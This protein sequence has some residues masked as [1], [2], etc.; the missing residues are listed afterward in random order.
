VTR[1]LRLFDRLWKFGLVGAIALVVDVG[2]FNLLTY[3]GG[4]GPLHDWPLLAKLL[5]SAAATIVSWLGNRSLTFRDRGNRRTHHELA[6][7][8]LACTLGAGIALGCLGISHYV[9]GLHSALADNIAA[10][11]VGLVLGTAFRFWAYHTVVFRGAKQPAADDE[12]QA[13]ETAT[14]L[15]AGRAG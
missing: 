3:A 11:V 9:L 6:L 1:L 14:A 5:S 12:A 10:N 7:F 15:P 8:V 13:G 4:E 2:G